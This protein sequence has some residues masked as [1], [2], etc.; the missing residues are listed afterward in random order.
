MN[1]KEVHDI[2]DQEPGRA[3]SEDTSEGGVTTS[4]YNNDN[5]D[6][7]SALEKGTPD[8]KGAPQAHASP[9][10]TEQG[11]EDPNIVFWDG[12]DDPE[13]PMNWPSKLKIINVT[14]VSTWTFLTPLASSM[15]APGILN[16]LRDFHS[17]SATLGSFVV[18]IY[19]LGY[20]LGPL[21]VAPMS[22]IYGR[23]PVYHVCNGLFVVWTLACAFAPSLGALLVFRFFQGAVGVCALT[24]GSGTI[25]D[26]IPTEK[27]G[28][29]MS[30]YSIGPLLGPGEFTLHSFSLVSCFQE[31]FCFVRTTKLTYA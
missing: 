10:T 27:R 21:V 26:L 15:V 19:I 7:P 18:S 20:A 9:T 11:S 4:T 25:S 14:L 8:G 30:V 5:Q 12:P 22:E 1:E 28:K 6:N 29:F 17:D 13:N 3:G 23:L 24:I 16:I 2:Q 31:F